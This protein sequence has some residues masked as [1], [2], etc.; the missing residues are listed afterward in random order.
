SLP[1]CCAPGEARR[2]R[3][4]EPSRMSWLTYGQAL[5]LQRT[6]PVRLTEVPVEYALSLPVPT[7]RWRQPSYAQFAA[8]MVRRPEEAPICAVPDRWWAIDAAHGQLMVYA[9]VMVLP[10]AAEATFS[11]TPL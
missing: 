9:R 10:F 3:A 4:M 2:S 5:D 8:P 1:S 6:H 11:A 7:C